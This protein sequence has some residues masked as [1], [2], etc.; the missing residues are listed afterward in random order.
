MFRDM[1]IVM[2]RN[3]DDNILKQIA[4]ETINC[5]KVAIATLKIVI[6]MFRGKKIAMAM[7]LKLQIT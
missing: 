1:K 6:A 4:I 7:Q 3:C 2:H 5:I